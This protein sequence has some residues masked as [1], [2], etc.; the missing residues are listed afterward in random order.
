M[1]A[2][3]LCGGFGSRLRALIG[4]TQKAMV[5]VHGEPL[6]LHVLCRLQAAG[7]SEA[8]LCAHYQAGQLAEQLDS[9]R[10]RSGLA[11]T[12][13]CEHSP[14][15]TGGALLNALQQ[16]PPS[17]SYLV[18]NADTLLEPD[19]YRL[20]AAARGNVLVAVQ[21]AE[22]SRYG[23]LVLDEHGRLRALQ[24]KA[25][26][27][28]GLVNAGVYGFTPTTWNT[29]PVRACSMEQ[30]LLPELL[31][32]EPLAVLE[33]RGEFIDIG[34]PEALLAVRSRQPEGLSR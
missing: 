33:Y 11:L 9:L 30:S 26:Q 4:E 25:Q 18:L 23:S 7:I 28:P 32:R 15:G 34:T 14:L 16:C 6:L 3:V 12:L 1:R 20:A 24:E 5:T 19:A 31:S 10:T 13:V 17:S 8:V 29:Q 2:Y 21:V 22:R 27:G